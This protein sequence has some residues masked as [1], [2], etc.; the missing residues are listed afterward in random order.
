MSFIDN[1]T[2]RFLGDPEEEFYEDEYY[3][4]PA[5]TGR[6]RATSPTRLLG[7]PPRPEVESVSVYTRSGRPVST[8]GSY[9]APQPAYVP[10]MPQSTPSY[11]IGYTAS[12]Q[13]SLG[14]HL[15]AYVLRPVSYDDVQTVV[16]RAKTGQPLILVF[17]HTN[18]EVAKRILDF[19]F[20]LSYGLNGEIKELGDRVFAVLPEGASITPQDLDKLRADGDLSR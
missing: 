6:S 14:A 18:I 9:E 7:N 20:G 4:Q 5:D 15:P 8:R 12:T 3:D 19:C 2:R 10:D 17:K 13:R 1:L 11:P 16:Q